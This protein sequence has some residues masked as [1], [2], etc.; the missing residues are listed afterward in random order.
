MAAPTSDQPLAGLR[1]VEVST[2]VAAPLGGMTLAQLGAEVVRVDPLGGAPDHYRWPL[3]DSGTSLYWAGLNKG[4]RSVVVDLHSAAGQ[5]LVTR[6]VADSGAGG[7]IVLTNSVGRPWLGYEALAGRRPD[8]IHLQIEGHADGSAAV[9][10]TVNAGLGF[11]LLTGP[12]GHAGPV[13]HVLPAWDVACGLYAAVGLLAAVHR[14]TITAQGTAISVALSD[15]ALATAGNLG[16]LA[17]AQLGQH[18]PRVGNYLYGGFGRDFASRDGRRFML[19]TLTTRHWRDLVAAT[20]LGEPVAALERSLGVDFTVE[21]DRYECRELLAALLERWFGE[22]DF[23][24]IRA[25]LD[26]TSVLWSAYRS[27]GELVDGNELSTNPLMG[28]VD[29]PGLGP[30]LAPGS[31]IRAGNRTVTR[32]PVLGEH[33]DEILT[34]WLDPDPGEVRALHDRGVIESIQATPAHVAAARKET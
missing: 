29:Q 31:P 6:L 4:K 15:V 3:A 13:N 19:V 28:V 2:F 26:G 8:I 30:Y 12:A 24:D 5:E 23:A 16:F 25:V 1:I 18:R 32:A 9:D 27:F 17:E 11:P 34:T 10:Y 14:R 7:G 21:G 22:R 20:G 33:T